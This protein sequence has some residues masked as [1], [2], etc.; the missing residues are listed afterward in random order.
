MVVYHG[1]SKTQFETEFLNRQDVV[2]TTYQTLANE[3]KVCGHVSF[4]WG[5]VE[6]QKQP[7]RDF[8]AV[9]CFMPTCQ[10]RL[11]MVVMK[12]AE[13]RL[14]VRHQVGA[15]RSR[16]GSRDPQPELV[17]GEG[18][19][20]AQVSAKVGSIRYQMLIGN[21]FRTE[22]FLFHSAN[23]YEN[24]REVFPRRNFTLSK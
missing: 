9:F 5:F 4:P 20:R 7:K 24:R 13:I 1:T 22:F 12:L 21:F 2:I 15:C 16:R 3:Y 17:T 14:L 8:L 10:Y 6:M 19:L 18:L 23:L 11:F